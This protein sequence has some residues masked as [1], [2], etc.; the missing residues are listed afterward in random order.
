MCRLCL[1]M[2]VLFGFSCGQSS[3]TTAPPPPSQIHDVH[4]TALVRDHHTAAQYTGHRI[5][6]RLDPTDYEC[7]SGEIHV[8]ITQRAVPPVIVCRSDRSLADAKGRIVLVGFC[9]SVERDGRWRSPRCDFVVTLNECSFTV[10]QEGAT[11]AQ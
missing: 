4:W 9:H 7:V 6:L 5:R 8:W 10:R 11:S 1:L 3:P 2:L